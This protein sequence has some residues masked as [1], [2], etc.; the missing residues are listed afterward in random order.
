MNPSRIDPPGPERHG[1]GDLPKRRLRPPLRHRSQPQLHQ[2]ASPKNRLPKRTRRA[3]PK[4]H[5]LPRPMTLDPRRKPRVQRLPNRTRRWPS[6]PP[7]PMSPNPRLQPR[8]ASSLSPRC[9]GAFPHCQRAPSRACR[10]W[11]RLPERPVRMMRPAQDLRPGPCH[12]HRWRW[13]QRSSRCWPSH[14]HRQP[15]RPL[16]R[17]T[18]LRPCPSKWIPRPQRSPWCPILGFPSPR[19][20]CL[21]RLR[22]LSL[23]P[24]PSFRRPIRPS[25]APSPAQH[26]PWS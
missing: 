9:P 6:R 19:P 2:K 16:A 25:P 8:S 10:T 15:S 22:P 12:P 23:P 18:L 3:T 7:R 5:L 1:Q 20:R 21:R 4:R 11:E 13:R 24:H 17:P 14:P 26:P